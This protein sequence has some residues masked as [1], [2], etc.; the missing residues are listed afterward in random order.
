[1][2]GG[3]FIEA[4]LPLSSSRCAFVQA[5][6]TGRLPVWR[7]AADRLL[8]SSKLHHS[9]SQERLQQAG[10][11]HTVRKHPVTGRWEAAPTLDGRIQMLGLADASNDSE[12]A[13]GH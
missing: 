8:Q 3:A 2:H 6:V 5:G 9:R 13:S 11:S 1:V 12:V 7:R 4:R 10:V